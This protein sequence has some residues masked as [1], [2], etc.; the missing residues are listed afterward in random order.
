MSKE[1]TPEQRLARSSLELPAALPAF[2]QYVPAVLR[3]SQLWVGGHFGTRPDG[4]LHVGR[5]GQDVSVGQAREAA[6]SAAINLLATVREALGTL[7][8]V[9]QVVQVYGV[10]NST[11]DFLEHTSVIDAAS[12]ALVEVFGDAGRHT[13]LAV[14]V[15]SLPANLVLEI[16]AMILV[17]P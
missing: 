2:G 8:R 9:E 12:D 11:P 7:D 16:Q 1:P 13:R 5:C 3:G 17:G 4:S 6:R 10:V 14:G 15:S